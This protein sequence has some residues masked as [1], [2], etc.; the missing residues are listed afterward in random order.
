MRTALFVQAR[1]G[2]SRLPGKVLKE[3]LGKPLLSYLLERL[4][5]VKEASDLRIL[6]TN[7]ERDDSIERLCRQEGVVCF[8]G[9]EEDV[10]ERYYQAALQTPVDLIVRITAD[11]PLIDPAVIDKVIQAH[12]QKISSIDYT[13]NSLELTF[14]RGMDVEVISLKALEKAF[15]EGK[16]ADEREHVTPYIYRHPELFRL[17]NV[18]HNPPL[19]HLRLTVDTVEDFKL[20]RL[21]LE[22]IYPNNPVFELNDIL[23]CLKEHPEWLRI[24]A[25][26]EQKKIIRK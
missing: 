20:I 24:N 22:R 23:N 17:A 13:S 25:H 1:M 16:R 26:I 15:L 2:S 11:C 6:T 3:V 8:R 12:L 7:N 10:L 21:I 9:S 19:G 14:P 18:A 4:K 5:R